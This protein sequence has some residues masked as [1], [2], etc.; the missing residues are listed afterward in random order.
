MNH[1]KH[2]LENRMPSY[3]PSDPL[4]PVQWHLLNTGNTI[5]SIAG[6]DINVVRVW[7]DYSGA[8]V[9]VTATEAGMDETSY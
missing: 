3:I 1:I 4:F 5:G 7:P 9:L 2:H 6:F 8:G